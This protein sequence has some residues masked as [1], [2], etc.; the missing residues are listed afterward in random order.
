MTLPTNLQF[1]VEN[2]QSDVYVD[3]SLK[4]LFVMYVVDQAYVLSFIILVINL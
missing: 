3:W 2:M 1:S 4:F